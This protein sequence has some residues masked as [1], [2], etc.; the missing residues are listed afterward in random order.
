[1]TLCGCNTS[2]RFYCRKVSVIFP[3]MKDQN[4]PWSGSDLKWVQCLSVNRQ[5]F[6]L[7]RNNTWSLLE[8]VFYFG[9]CG[10]H[11]FNDVN[12]VRFNYTIDFKSAKA[13]PVKALR[14]SGVI[15]IRFFSENVLLKLINVKIHF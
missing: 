11:D 8:E 6:L 5:H 4:E 12:V 10:S 1:M 14:P 9:L 3:N 13:I 2:H 7:E 15:K